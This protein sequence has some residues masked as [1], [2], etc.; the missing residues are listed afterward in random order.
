MVQSFGFHSSLS[1]YTILLPTTFLMFFICWLEIH[2]TIY[3]DL[4]FALFSIYLHCIEN[5]FFKS[6]FDPFFIAACSFM[7]RH[8]LYS[9]VGVDR[10]Y[11]F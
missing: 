11:D 1:H 2:H 7:G 4:D 10:E 6:Y 9:I 3:D 8:F 5:F